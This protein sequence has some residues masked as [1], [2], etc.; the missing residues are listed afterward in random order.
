MTALLFTNKE[1]DV[2][3]ADKSGDVYRFVDLGDFSSELESNFTIRQFHNHM[4]SSYKHSGG[5]LVLTSKSL[6]QLFT[7]SIPSS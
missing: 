2:V 7:R 6:S 4:H 5:P 3:V 1:N